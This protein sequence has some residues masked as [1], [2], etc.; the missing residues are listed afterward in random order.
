ME[1]VNSF[2]KNISD[3]SKN[4]SYFNQRVKKEENAAL[5]VS[6][7]TD[8][9]TQIKDN[10][11]VKNTGIPARSKFLDKFIEASQKAPYGELAD[12]SGIINYNGVIF[13]CDF[14][15]NTISL[16]DMAD[17]SKILTIPLSGG[18]R[19][20][21]NV[22]SID[23]LAKAIDMFNANDRKRIMDALAIYAKVQSK[24]YEMEEEQNS[25]FQKLV[26][27]NRK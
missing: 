13:Q 3:Y 12:E 20:R 10:N 27:K 8:I 6:N 22:N 11:T 23:D 24:K 16:G 4:A 15:R 5:P 14:E 9:E 1:L 17:E 26:E 25:L 2:S 7:S 19:L 21:V 18:G